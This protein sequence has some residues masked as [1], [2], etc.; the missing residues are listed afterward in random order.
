MKIRSKRHRQFVSQQPCIITG[1]IHETNH[2]HHLLRV[3]GKAMGTKACDSWCVPLHWTLHNALHRNGNE[4]VF[5]ANHG[6]D[7]EAVKQIA[8][9]L[10]NKSP[11]LR[12]RHR[13]CE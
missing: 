9:D 13:E 6:L 7:Y 2:A 3:E 8:R 4:I 1:N 11:D 12:I 10:S 5:F